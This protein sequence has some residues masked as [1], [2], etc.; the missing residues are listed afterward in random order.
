MV[1]EAVGEMVEVAR[2][3]GAPLHLSHLKVI[4]NEDRVEPLLELIDDAARDVDLTFDQYPYGAGSTTLAAL[5]PPWAQADGREATLGRLSEPGVRRELVR[6]IET[7]LPGWENI[8][9]SCGSNRIVVVDAPRTHA[10]LIGRSLAEIGTERRIDP[11]VAVLDILLETGLGL[12]MIDHYATEHVV[13]RIF[14]HPRALVG[15]NGIFGAHP[16]P[17]LHATAA[18]VL[19]RYALREGL[20]T[21]EEAVARLTSRPADRLGLADR[22]RIRVGLR[23]DLVLL[24]PA[25][26]VD[27]ATYEDPDQ[28]PPGVAAVFV[29]GRLIHR[30]GQATGERPGEVVRTPRGIQP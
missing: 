21:A 27:T 10:E 2:R 12:T 16:H 4:G 5:L 8:Y 9:A 7:G 24:D 22:G 29:G 6:D 26:Y 1:I 28:S 17:R 11:V 13:R 14:T 15:S 20:I 3:S 30:A 19:G 18:R 23:A 25:T